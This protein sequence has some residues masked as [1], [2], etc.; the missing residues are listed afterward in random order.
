MSFWPAFS[1]KIPSPSSIPLSVPCG[2]GASKAVLWLQM[3]KFIKH[4]ASKKKQDK[5]LAADRYHYLTGHLNV[6]QKWLGK[7]CPN[8]WTGVLNWA[9][10][11]QS[12]AVSQGWAFFLCSYHR[13]FL[14]NVINN[15]GLREK[16]FPLAV[17]QGAMFLILPAICYSPLSLL[18]GHRGSLTQDRSFEGHLE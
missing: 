3:G 10:S 7:S 9:T 8:S 4:G 17:L 18:Q 13:R 16:S 2:E 6:H 14:Y 5:Y 12:R 15:S 1:C 11:W